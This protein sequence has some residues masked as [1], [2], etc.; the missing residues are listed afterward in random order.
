MENVVCTCFSVPRTVTVPTNGVEH[1]VLVAQV[2]QISQSECDLLPLVQV[3]LS[4]AFFHETVPSKCTSAF[5]SALVTNTSSLPILPAA[6]SIYLNNSFV[7]K[8]SKRNGS[9]S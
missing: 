3:E 7:S 5:L 1:K 2:T 4:C 9:P 8:V 6:A